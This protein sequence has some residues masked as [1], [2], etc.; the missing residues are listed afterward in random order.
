MCF[1]VSFTRVHHYWHISSLGFA[2]LEELC[3][4]KKGTLYYQMKIR[5]EKNPDICEGE[6]REQRSEEWL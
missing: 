1:R 6:R 4:I 5:A 3:G 2:H